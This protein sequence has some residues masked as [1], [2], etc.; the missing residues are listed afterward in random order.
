VVGSESFATD[1]NLTQADA[2]K[3]NSTAEEDWEIDKINLE[4]APKAVVEYLLTLD[5]EAFG[6][7]TNV[8]PKFTP[9]RRVSAS[10]SLYAMTCR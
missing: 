10:R 2:K 4:T 9:T 8:T 6:A 7:A 1:P 3:Q 5:G